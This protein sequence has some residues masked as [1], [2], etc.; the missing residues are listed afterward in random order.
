MPCNPRRTARWIRTAATSSLIA[1]GALLLPALAHAQEFVSIKGK[2]VNV[3]EQP[4]TR[5]ATLWE[6]SRGYP[7]QVTQRKGQWLRVKDYEST[8]GWVHAPLTS[9]SP[10]MVVTARTANL[11]SGP[12]LKHNRVG[13]LEQHEVLQTLKKQGS[14]AQ[15]QRSNGQSGWVAKNLVWGW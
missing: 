7:L 6:L 1:L 2:T 10:H 15:V 5:S 13:K 9:K 3:R 14:W 11:R 12:G 4:N 8:L